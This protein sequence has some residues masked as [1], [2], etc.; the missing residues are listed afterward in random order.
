VWQTRVAD[1]K[2]GYTITVAPLAVR[3]K[4]I[5]GVAG[6]EYGIRGFLDAYDA[7]SGR[8]AWRFYTIPGPNEPGND[9]WTDG[10]SWRTGGGPTWVTGSFDPDLGLVYWGV[11]NPSPNFDGTVRPGNNL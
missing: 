3:D 4:I 8:R 10:E 1:Y 9:T 11:G 5:V 2:A 7:N 6:G